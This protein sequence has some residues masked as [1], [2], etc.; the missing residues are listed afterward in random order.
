MKKAKRHLPINR[1]IMIRSVRIDVNSQN[2]LYVLDAKNAKV[3]KFGADG[4]K[5]IAFGR[6]GASDGEFDTDASDIEID[7]EGNVLIADTGNHR[8]IKFNADGEYIL[9]FGGE[10]T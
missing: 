1:G 7:A 10:G 6:Y 3:Y 8:V 2:Q 5:L 4:E 9:K